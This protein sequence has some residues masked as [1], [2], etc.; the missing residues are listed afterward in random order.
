MRAWTRSTLRMDVSIWATVLVSA[1]AVSLIY[2]R[3]GLG[4]L[5]ALLFL[6]FAPIAGWLF[7]SPQTP[8]NARAQGLWA[9]GTVPLVAY[10]FEIW[11]GKTDIGRPMSVVVATVVLPISFAVL[12]VPVVIVASAA[13]ALARVRR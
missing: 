9:A 13:L 12:A 1:G 7:A 6:A 11:Q 4:P 3:G 5:F 8:G 2:L 10:A